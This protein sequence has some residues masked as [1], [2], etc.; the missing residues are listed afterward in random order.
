LIFSTGYHGDG[1]KC[2]TQSCDISNNCGEHARC[3]LDSLTQ[4]YRCVCMQGYI[5][6]G[7]KCVFDCKITNK[8]IY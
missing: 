1:F 4:N 6:N 8:H 7:F 3:L 5:G 2:T